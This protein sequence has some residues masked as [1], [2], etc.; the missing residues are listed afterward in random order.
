M[1]KHD[2]CIAKKFSKFSF[3]CSFFLMSH[4]GSLKWWVKSCYLAKREQVQK[5]FFKYIF[6]VKFV[7]ILIKYP[8]LKKFMNFFDSVQCV[9]SIFSGNMPPI[10]VKP[11]SGQFP[12]FD[13]FDV[14]ITT[15]R[16]KRDIDCAIIFK[17]SMV[18]NKKKSLATTSR[19]LLEPFVIHV[20]YMFCPMC[21]L[22]M[23]KL[24]KFNWYW[25]PLNKIKVVCT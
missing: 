15:C 23:C 21:I 11:S 8:F 24:H 6:R 10:R 9:R 7:N 1:G 5:M 25:V 18:Q 2:K 3:L 4:Y 19:F 16:R 12:N 22:C 13:K 20:V 14:I 17:F